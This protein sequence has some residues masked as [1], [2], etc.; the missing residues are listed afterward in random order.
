MV[1]VQLPYHDNR[2]F[3]KLQLTSA[4][5]TKKDHVAFLMT[6]EYSLAKKNAIPS[7]KAL[8]WMED[9]HA[10]IRQL[11]KGCITEKLEDVFVRLD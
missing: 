7:D 6:T 8:G 11:F 10:T 2:D 9:A 4:M 3:C 5:A 1:G